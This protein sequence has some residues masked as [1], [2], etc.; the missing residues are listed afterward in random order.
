MD[1]L[2]Q[3]FIAGGLILALIVFARVVNKKHSGRRKRR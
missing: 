3:I 2:T 1:N